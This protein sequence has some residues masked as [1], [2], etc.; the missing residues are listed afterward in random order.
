MIK[1]RFELTEQNY[2]Y[3]F[4]NASDAMWVHDLEGNFIVA[5]NKASEKLTGYP[6]EEL[7]GLN[8]RTFLTGEFLGIWHLMG[9]FGAMSGPLLI[10]VI[11]QG[12]GLQTA[13]F[14]I[15]AF[16]I[17]GAWIMIFKVTE[18]LSKKRGDT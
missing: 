16:G 2:R 10:G 14:L 4:E 17:A 3:L 12:L 5:N 6:V 7:I 15:A 18:T 8:V 1:P 13:P 11:A 9:D